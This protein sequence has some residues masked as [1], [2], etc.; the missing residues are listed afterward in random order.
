MAQSKDTQKEYE[1]LKDS[2]GMKKGT[3]K[4]LSDSLGSKLVSMKIVKLAS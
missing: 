2:A 3:K 1:Y 4:R